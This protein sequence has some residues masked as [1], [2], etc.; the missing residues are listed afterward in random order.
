MSR[1]RHE[2]GETSSGN[3]HKTLRENI[4]LNGRG[5]S[6]KQP[7]VV[8]EMEELK[9]S[10]MFERCKELD[11]PLQAHAWKGIHSQVRAEDEDHH[12]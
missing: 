1:Y 12:T 4:I 9:L 2:T 10:R 3:R 5:G 8:E 11:I 6:I 7:L